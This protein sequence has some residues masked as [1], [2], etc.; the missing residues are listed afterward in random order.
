VNGQERAMS[1]SPPKRLR[2]CAVCVADGHLL[3]VRLRDPVT[4]EEGVYPPGGAVEPGETPAE[5]ARRET[6]EETG[7][8][9]RVHA[10]RVLVDTYPFRWAG[11]DREITTHYFAASLEDPFSLTLPNV[12]DAD[13]NLGP[14]WLPIREALAAM[15]LHPAIAKATLHVLALPEAGILTSR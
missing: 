12:T 13:Y 1:N 10:E 7:L 2:A 14:V 15:A 11:V 6:R 5:T 9:V 4:G 8:Q 3:L